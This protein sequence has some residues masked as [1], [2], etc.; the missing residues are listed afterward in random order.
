MQLPHCGHSSAAEVTRATFGVLT[1]LVERLLSRDGCGL[2]LSVT[3]SSATAERQRVSY[4]RLSRLALWSCTS[5]NN[6]SVVIG[7]NR[8]ARLVFVSTLSANKPC[9]IRGRGSFQTLYTFKVT[10]LSIMPHISR[11]LRD[12]AA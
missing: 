11:Y 1:F 6:A 2:S 12:S 9:D 4:A 10:R 8:L 3:R 5:L 7:Y